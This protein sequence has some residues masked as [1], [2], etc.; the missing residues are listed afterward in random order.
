MSASLK[1]QLP[2]SATDSYGNNVIS[3]VAK[4]DDNY[5]SGLKPDKYQGITEMNDLIIDPGEPGK[6]GTLLLFMN[7]W[8]FPDRRKYQ[9]RAF[10]NRIKSKLTPPIIQVI[11]KTGEW[12]TVIDNLGFP[13]G[14]DK[15]IIA[16]LSGKFPTSDHRIRIRTNMEIYW[17]YI[18]F[19][20]D[21]PECENYANQN[22]SCK[23]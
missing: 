23:S 20:K 13:M 16:D 11:N 5:L 6:S 17:D 12:E 8:I 22:E 7:G 4:K 19:S 21:N 10:L 15:T 1:K 2:V 18:F 9:C 14:K 3:A